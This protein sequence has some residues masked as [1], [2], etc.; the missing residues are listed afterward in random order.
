MT[1]VRLIGNERRSG[2]LVAGP[3][4]RD[5]TGGFGWHMVND[6]AL[7]T[8]ITPG[9][10][11]GK[12][13]RAL[14]PRQPGGPPW[15]A[16]EGARPRQRPGAP[17]AGCRIR[18]RWPSWLMSSPPSATS[19]AT[20]STPGGSPRSA[21]SGW[22]GPVVTMH[23]Q[24]RRSGLSHRTL[25]TLRAGRRRP[26]REGNPRVQPADAAVADLRNR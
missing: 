3:D 8:V 24:C 13:V 16:R 26:V 5:E 2:A 12:T 14:L 22:T 18:Q 1:C 25:R 9:P 20:G 4:L 10:E 7:A 11:G 21:T 6:L 17:V 19:A 23:D 15:P